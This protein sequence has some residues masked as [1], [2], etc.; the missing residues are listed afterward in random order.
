LVDLPRS[1]AGK[2]FKALVSSKYERGIV[3]KS[4][5]YPSS[6]GARVGTL[7]SVSVLVGLGLLIN[8]A[9]RKYSRRGFTLEKHESCLFRI[10]LASEKIAECDVCSN[11]VES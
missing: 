3:Q 2:F 7:S 8:T 11:S 9:K 4:D 1:N 10:I 5:P 6:D